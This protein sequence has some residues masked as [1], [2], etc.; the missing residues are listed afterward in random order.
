MVEAGMTAQ[1]ALIAGTSNAA[2]LIGEP[3]RGT[4]E[5]G[6]VADMVLLDGNPLEN[7]DALR[8]V[9]AVY[10]GGQRVA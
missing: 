4:I 2:K 8:L 5:V 10:Q 7:I 6:K 3:E 9:A 1:D